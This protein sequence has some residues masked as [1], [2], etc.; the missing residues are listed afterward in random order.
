MNKY[1]YKMINWI[2]RFNTINE[3]IYKDGAES[4]EKIKL[5]PEYGIAVEC[6]RK[7]KNENNYEFIDRIT[8]KN[9]QSLYYARKGYGFF[10]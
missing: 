7:Y 5:S 1:Q 8:C 4:K 6:Y 10:W 9:W 3:I 2:S